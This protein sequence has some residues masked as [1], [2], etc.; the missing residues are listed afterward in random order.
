MMPSQPS[1][2]LTEIDDTINLRD[3]WRI[4]MQRRRLIAGVMFALAGLAAVYV[5][6]KPDIYQSTATLMP[7][8]QSNRG[9]RAVLG[10]MG[11]LLPAG[12]GDAESP[13]ERILAILHSRTVAEQVIEQLTLLPRLFPGDWN[14]ETGQWQSDTPRTLQDGVRALRQLTGIREEQKTGLIRI[15]AE[16]TDPQLAA[17]IANQY[18]QVLQT[19]LN[20]NA[21]SLAKKNRQF[22]E[23]QLAATRRGLAVAEDALQRFEQ[24]HGIIALEAQANAA[25]NAIAE[26]RKQMMATELQLRILKRSVTGA[27]R[28]AAILQEEL[29]GLR[30]QL[31]RLEHGVEPSNANVVGAAGPQAFL[32]FQQAPEIKRDYLR[33]QR[34]VRIQTEL[35]TLL[36]QQLEEA[37]IR[38]A[39]DETAFQVVDLA[40]AAE[41]KSKPW[42]GLSVALAMM[43]G[44]LIGCFLAL[45]SDYHDVTVRSVDQVERQLRTPVLATVAVNGLTDWRQRADAAARDRVAW[46][47]AADTPEC[48]ALRYVYTRLRRERG[49]RDANVLLLTS[50]QD[51]DACSPML[52][53]LALAATSM[54]EK[55]LLL[56][57]NIR[58]PSLHR[59]LAVPPVPGLADILSDSG[60]W[61][62][63]IQT[64][65]INNLHLLPAGHITAASPMAL[66]SPAFDALIAYS[67]EAYDAVFC[68]AAPVLAGSDAAVV[69]GKVDATCL[70]IQRGS[71]SVEAVGEALSTLQGVQAVVAGA[72]LTHT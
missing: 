54:G 42:R 1:I 40:I 5:F 28:E 27:S 38:E 24:Q 31:T 66:A 9:L 48:E 39:R 43:M 67:K 46:A 22:I 71:S 32:A 30:A 62:K 12:L 23:T 69:S 70:L 72:I 37:K 4:L 18:V 8:G 61:R 60:D 65:A 52:V 13:T 51:H 47:P 10:E 68:T 41:R 14:A 6:L 45:V 2:P 50:E 7:L 36:T 56:D 35:F 53:A 11:G 15:S 64:T 3:Y 34:G 55:V 63:G 29:R 25:I 58:Q 26:V 44:A 16:F 19:S 59:L 17:L 21:F 20:A 57:G 33:L 49:D